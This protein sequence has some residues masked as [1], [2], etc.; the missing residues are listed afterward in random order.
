MSKHPGLVTSESLKDHKPFLFIIYLRDFI[1]VRE[2]LLMHNSSSLQHTHAYTQTHTHTHSHIYSQYIHSQPR[3]YILTMHTYT[4]THTHT[5]T[6]TYIHT[7]TYIDTHS[8]HTHTV[9]RAL[10]S[11]DRLNLTLA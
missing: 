10:E 1:I 5:Y 11:V 9:P 4:H 6:H 3:T 8:P 7:Y 2:S